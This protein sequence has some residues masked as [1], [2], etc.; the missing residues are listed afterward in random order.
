MFQL[1]RE[2]APARLGNLGRPRGTLPF[3]PAIVVAA[4]A[5]LVACLGCEPESAE[6]FASFERIWGSRG[7]TDGR[8]QKPRAIAIDAEDRVYVVD[9]TAR[10]QVFQSDGR[11]LRAWSTPDHQFGKPTGL[12]VGID[13][14]ILVADTHYYQILI[15]SPEGQLDQTIGGVQG[16]RPGEF[17]FVTDA[18]QDS[19]GNYYVAEYGEYDRIQKFSPSGQFLGAWG[20]HGSEPGRFMRPQS[21]AVDEHDHIWVADACNHRI[22]Q[23]DRQGRL[24]Q[25][26]GTQGGA[27]GEL[28]YPYDLVLDSAGTVLVAEFG[29]HR[30]QR[31]TRDGRSLGVWG[32]QGRGEG[33]LYN[34]WALVQ[35]QQGRIHVLDTNNHRVQVIRPQAANHR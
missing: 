27:A 35:D 4:L 5:V 14:R 32:A 21:L 8:F 2:V 13:G 34:P 15:Y 16:E 22:Q 12:S 30:V 9:M 17:G 11:F 23:F 28:H 33:Q 7:I 6:S 19:Q 24:L 31:F 10:I 1:G 26:W 29:N 25:M 20:G 3:G 18:V